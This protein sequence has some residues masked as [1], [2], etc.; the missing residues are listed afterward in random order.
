MLQGRGPTSVGWTV[1]KSYP[2]QR[3]RPVLGGVEGKAQPRGA[4]SVLSVRE[5]KCREERQVYEPEGG[6]MV[7]PDLA[8]RSG[9][10]RERRRKLFRQVP[11]GNEARDV[12]ARIHLLRIISLP[13]E[14]CYANLLEA[15]LMARVRACL[16]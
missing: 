9:K 2:F 3:V 14:D 5:R 13:D 10:A 1:Q 7:P 4:R 15:E 6:N 11:H 16:H 8:S 12:K